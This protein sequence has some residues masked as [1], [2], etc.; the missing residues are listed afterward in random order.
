MNIEQ[1]RKRLERSTF[2]RDILNLNPIEL[3]RMRRLLPAG[4]WDKISNLRPVEMPD[5]PNVVACYGGIIICCT[6]MPEYRARLREAEI[7]ELSAW[8]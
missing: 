1:F 5:D 3:L 4:V 6:D 8:L 2:G 7:E